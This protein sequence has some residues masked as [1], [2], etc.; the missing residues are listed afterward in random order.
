MPPRRKSDG[1]DETSQLSRHGGRDWHEVEFYVME[2][3]REGKTDLEKLE[4]RI[5]TTEDQVDHTVNRL[6]VHDAKIAFWSA[7]VGFTAAVVAN[8]L[9]RWLL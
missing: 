7:L 4:D 9:I 5:K 3:L 8:A 6:D 1:D 2:K